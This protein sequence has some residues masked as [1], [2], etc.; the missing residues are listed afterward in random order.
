MPP[1][2]EM[3]R[4]WWFI[5]LIPVLAPVTWFYWDPNYYIFAGDTP[6]WGGFQYLIEWHFPYLWDELDGAGHPFANNAPLPTA[7]FFWLLWK[8]SVPTLAAQ[9]AFFV[10]LSALS[11]IGIYRVGRLYF[12]HDTRLL[13]VFVAAIIYLLNPF[14]FYGENRR[15]FTTEFLVAYYLLPLFVSYLLTALSIEKLVTREALLAGLTS[16]ALHNFNL[17]P[18]LSYLGLAFVAIVIF[19]VFVQARNRFAIFKFSV[20]F[21][22]V[23]FLLAAYHL[24]AMFDYYKVSSLASDLGKIVP[25]E[26]H[27]TAD[28]LIRTLMFTAGGREISSLPQV[29]AYLLPLFVGIIALYRSPSRLLVGACGAMLVLSLFLMDAGFWATKLFGLTEAT[30]Y[31]YAIFRFPHIKF[32]APYILSVALLCGIVA[33]RF[34]NRKLIVVAASILF[35]MTWN[36]RA[37]V[38]W[39]PI[40]L[41]KPDNWLALSEFMQR[42][43]V[44][45]R[46]P[47]TVKAPS[48]V[49][50]QDGVGGEEFARTPPQRSAGAQPDPWMVHGTALGLLL[51]HPIFSLD[52]TVGAKL[53]PCVGRIFHAKPDQQELAALFRMLGIERVLLSTRFAY[54][55]QFTPAETMDRMRQLMES[56]RPPLLSNPPQFQNDGVSLSRVAVEPLPL[57]YTAAEATRVTPN[58]F[59]TCTF[60]I[61]SANS[62]NAAVFYSAPPK[63]GQPSDINRSTAT[64]V[65]AS[66][67][68]EAPGKY[69]VRLRGVPTSGV[70]VLV[71]N[72]SYADW[73]IGAPDGPASAGGGR[74]RRFPVNGFA[75]A[76]ALDAS[77][78]CK[79][80]PCRTNP[81]GGNDVDLV[82]SYAPQA[83]Y[84]AMLFGMIMGVVCLSITVLFLTFRRRS[85][86][87]GESA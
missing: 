55:A 74:E 38:H 12:G 10:I 80:L 9:A 6:A 75:T 31:F 24:F 83:I 68:R 11:V 8:L 48:V 65:V 23:S 16:I 27:S 17:I 72:N 44:E 19:A 2:N 58:E 64:T 63:I 43:R 26:I 78:L 67:E 33:A 59:A 84:E 34:Q 49:Y 22:S 76:W 29:S 13:F 54:Q 61:T 66:Y 53:N 62:P 60:P 20:I 85:A 28:L 30:S 47:R 1:K 86:V 41:H 45:K 73:V 57:V 77:S 7:L 5:L 4:H 39:M 3:S 25:T 42:E 71:L 46:L 81:T 37:F 56:L 69:R 14:G 52:M 51:P 32:T 35:I 15:I 40:Q 70:V 18:T 87:H 82:I 50:F 21:L 79:S 36:D